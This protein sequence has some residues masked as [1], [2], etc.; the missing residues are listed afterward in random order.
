MF[1]KVKI[2]QSIFFGLWN[3]VL[4]ALKPEIVNWAFSGVSRY[5]YQLEG[6][7]HAISDISIRVGGQCL[8]SEASLSNMVLLWDN[9]VKF[10]I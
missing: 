1:Y 4:N 10:T 5:V 9:G 6:E 3:T 2:S 8:Q 7:S